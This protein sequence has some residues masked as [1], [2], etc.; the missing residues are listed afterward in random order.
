MI[1]TTEPVKA[2]FWVLPILALGGGYVFRD[3]IKN[4]I[5]G[6]FGEKVVGKKIGILGLPKSGKTKLA[7]FLI[8]REFPK[9]VEATMS[10]SSYKVNHKI[11]MKFAD[12]HIDVITD[13]RSHQGEIDY[14]KEEEIL[15]DC[16]IILYLFKASMCFNEPESKD[17]K[18]YFKSIRKEINTYADVIK[19][20]GKP[21]I[22]L[23]IGTHKDEIKGAI[24]KDL[25]SQIV[26]LLDAF[27]GSE[28]YKARYLNLYSVVSIDDA[29]RLEIDMVKTLKMIIGG[30]Q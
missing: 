6:G 22:F 26:S 28:L 10:N 18:K 27:S 20:M 23:L 29:E 7:T 2:F 17:S 24:N 5:T 4:L 9:E 15:R 1:E 8:E 12:L 16:D 21:R 19:T 25:E 13:S 11:S 14:G 30:V 3:E